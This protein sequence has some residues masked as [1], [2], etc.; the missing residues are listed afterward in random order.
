MFISSSSL[1]SPTPWVRAATH[2]RALAV[3]APPLTAACRRCPLSGYN[4]D[5]FTEEDAVNPRI[6][7]LQ[8]CGGGERLALSSCFLNV[9]SDPLQPCM[10]PSHVG[11]G[12][13]FARALLPTLPERDVVVLVPTGYPGEATP[14]SCSPAP[15]AHRRSA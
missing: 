15:A 9:S 11:F 4:S 12:R 10:G 3:Q 13:S 6:L 5:P 1:D 2:T 7:Q 8:C 14:S